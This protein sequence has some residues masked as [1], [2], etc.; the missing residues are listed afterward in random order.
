MDIVTKI[1]SKAVLVLIAVLCLI[2]TLF[3][4]D[5]VRVTAAEKAPLIDGVLDDPAWTQALVWT[6]FK[7]T[8][9]DFGLTP[10]EPTEFLFTYDAHHLYFAFRCG[11]SAPGRIK[12]SLSKRDDVVH[13]DYVSLFLDLSGTQQ[14]GYAFF[15]NPL[16]VQMDGTIAGDGEVD[17]SF[18]MV[19]K[20]SGRLTDAGYVVEAAVPLKSL[21]FPSRKEIICGIM[22]VR[23][24][25][26]KSE[27]MCAPAYN[28]KNGPVL[29]Q[30]GHV[31]ISGLAFER[32]VEGIPAM[33]FSRGNTR[34]AGLWAPS[35]QQ[36]DFSLTGKVGVTSDLTLDATY[37]PDFSQ[38]ETD[39]GQVDINLRNSLYYPE[40]RPFFLEGLEDFAFAGALEQNPLVAVVHTRTIVDPFLG[41]KL[42]GKVGGRNQVSSIFAL[43]EY[44]GG[45]AA[46][47]GQP[48]TDRKALFSI[49]RYKRLF[50]KDN[51][52]GGFFTGR[53][54]DGQANILGGLD[55]RFR[56][57]N[58]MSLESF[59]FNS[60]TDS[61]GAAGKA[62]RGEA[63]GLKYTFI[64]RKSSVYLGAY[65]IGRD[66]RTETGFVTRT[67]VR[68]L[69]GLANYKFYP[70]SKLF[71]RVD[72]YY[73]FTQTYDT[74]SG[75]FESQNYFALR[76]IMPRQTMIR[77]M[78]V[79]GNE[80]F[81][82][83]RFRRDGYW[84]SAGSQITKQLALQFSLI[85][86]KAIYYDPAAPYP[87]D[88]LSFTSALQLQLT[89]KLATELA[90]TYADFFRGS[91]GANIYDYLILRSKTT[92][93]VNKF[94]FFRGIFEYN[95]FRKRLTA[96]LL[97]SFTYIPGTVIHFGY[98][99]AY[100]RIRWSPEDGLYRPDDAFFQTKR[101]L[102]FKASYLWRF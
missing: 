60:W 56:L 92:F 84:L 61:P 59:A 1:F 7:T 3:G 63:L 36:T 52:L 85:D 81:A 76:V 10:T 50:S 78:A 18:D 32:T 68:M 21:R 77:V 11:D 24:V 66:F 53:G 73:Y 28:P 30:L 70:K 39:A 75:L 26:R 67:G 16:G 95:G 87:G 5:G 64:S 100:E 27:E 20:S 90:L 4:Q 86:T 99:S 72:P 49:V 9:P 14:T 13:D 83:Q 42:T 29:A 47:F 55:G 57:N 58:T 82:G 6:G 69:A 65:D 25:G 22:A 43:D 102:F 2:F 48:I 98:G 19:W 33:T 91:D 45:A 80:V 88:S 23:T 89:E 41:F 97:A 44:P 34:Q 94:L 40:K 79:V 31:G 15:V 93:Q 54:F 37:N 101:A 71:Q 96:D 38:V 62:R 46:D 51:Y 35:I 74:E 8:K 12:A 17:V